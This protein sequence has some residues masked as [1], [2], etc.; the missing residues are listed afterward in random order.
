MHKNGGNAMAENSTS[1][2][3]DRKKTGGRKVDVRNKVPTAIHTAIMAAIEKI[4]SDRAGKGGAVGYLMNLA[5]EHPGA[6]CKLLG[7]ILQME[8]KSEQKKRPLLYYSDQE[9][10]DEMRR[11]NLLPEDFLDSPSMKFDRSD[12][13]PVDKED[14]KR[15]S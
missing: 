12:S 8:M 3:P 14:Q 6:Y 9:L 7:R 1:F 10:L 4:G 2:K 5:V 13:I 11:R 15:Q